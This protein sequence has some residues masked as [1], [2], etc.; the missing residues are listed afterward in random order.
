MT[1]E[2]QHALQ[3]AEK[4]RLKEE[5]KSGSSS[6]KQKTNG[7]QANKV[8]PP[9]ADTLKNVGTAKPI[10]IQPPNLSTDCVLKDYQLEGVRWLASLFENGVSGI[11][12]DGM[13]HCALFDY[14]VPWK[15]TIW[16]FS[17]QF[18]LHFDAQRWVWV[19][20]FNVWH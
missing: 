9:A 8:Q 14:F 19:K 13:L 16:K 18:S 1:E 6:K 10:F 5:K 4:K 12:A 20:R 7:G 17:H 11:L 2:A 15:C 3:Q